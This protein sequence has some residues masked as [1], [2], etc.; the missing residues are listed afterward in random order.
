V[1]RKVSAPQ[2]LQASAWCTLCRSCCRWQLQG[3]QPKA[4]LC[5]PLLD[6][7]SFMLMKATPQV[8]VADG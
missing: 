5:N 4:K 1:C 8:H 7:Q 2:L 3:L 6:N